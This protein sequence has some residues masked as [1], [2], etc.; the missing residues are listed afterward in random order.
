MMNAEVDVRAVL[1]SINVPTLV[2]HRAGDR[3]IDPRHSHYLAE[4]IPGARYVELAG[5]EAISFGAESAALLD[6]IEEFLTGARHAADADRILATVMFADIVDSTARAAELGDRRWREELALIE[7]AM[8]R[9]LSRFR[10]RVVKTMGDSLL[11]TFDGPARAIR[12]ATAIRDGARAQFGIQMRSGLHTGEIE[13]IGNDV[14]GIAVHI[15]ARVGATAAPGEVLVS[16]TVK[17]LVVGSGIR[18][19]DRGERELRGVPGQWRLWAV[20]A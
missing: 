7:A 13:V 19:E 18:F 2:L 16:G 15:G 3:F 9:E 20:A 10:G 1:P 4:H 17:D 11:A 12:C 6:E 8:G 5:D 14:G